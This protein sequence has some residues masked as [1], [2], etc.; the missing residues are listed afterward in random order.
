[1]GLLLLAWLEV[2]FHIYRYIL[3][4]P[5]FFLAGAFVTKS[6]FPLG[7]NKGSLILILTY[8]RSV[9]LRTAIPPTRRRGAV[10]R[11]ASVLPRTTYS[12][13]EV[14]SKARPLAIVPDVKLLSQLKT[15]LLY[16]RCRSDVC[17][18]QTHSCEY[19]RGHPRASFSG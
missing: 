13:E 4:I 19:Q 3:C 15:V 16:I 5:V 1:M 8:F 2:T 7:I 17:L 14:V 6:N 18:T 10:E 12:Q 9:S 11:T